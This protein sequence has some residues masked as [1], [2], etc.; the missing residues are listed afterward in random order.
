MKI[1]KKTSSLNAQQQNVDEEET[2]KLKREQWKLFNLNNKEEIYSK[3]N[4]WSVQ[5]LCDNNKN[6][7][8]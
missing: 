4:K 1:K 3:K 8:K 2:M 5:E 7:L 6:Y